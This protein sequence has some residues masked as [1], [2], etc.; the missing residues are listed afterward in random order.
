MTI[1][2]GLSAL[3]AASEAIDATSNNIANAQTI[4]YKAGQYV[5][6]DQFFRATDPQNPNRTGMG[7]V[8]T[9]IRRPQTNGSIVATSNPLDLAIGGLGMFTTAQT[10]V[11]GSV[12][13]NPSNF[14]Y[15]RNG[16]FGVDNQNRIV[17]ENG[18][19]LVGYPANPDGTINTSQ[20]S[21]LT[22]SQA[23]LPGSQTLKSQV[24][25]NLDNTTNP[26]SSTFDPT[27][28]GTYSQSTS[29]TIYDSTGLPHT[30][31]LYYVKQ[32]SV[33]LV[34]TP[35][36]AAGTFTYD[37]QQA[38]SATPVTSSN[39]E[40]DGVNNP[41]LTANG[42]FPVGDNV[43]AQILDGNGNP[44]GAPQTLAP[45]GG[46]ANITFP[47][48]GTAPTAGAFSIVLTDT[49]TNAPPVG[50]STTVPAVIPK[51]ATTSFPSTSTIETLS[52]ASVSQVSGTT[53]L[54][55]LQD[56]STLTVTANTAV[57]PTSFTIPTS[58]FAIYATID[59]NPVPGGVTGST[60]QYN[61]FL[62]ANNGYPSGS[63][64][65]FSINGIP[66]T[67]LGTMAF[68][69]GKNIDSLA[70]DAYGVPNFATKMNISTTV[71][72]TNKNNV[73]FSIDSTNMTAYSAVGQ[74]Y[75]NS[76]DGA[77]LSQ[78]SSY[79]FDNNGQ[80]VAVYS[81]GQSKVQG[82]VKLAVFN[83]D[84]GLI[85]I[86]GNS[87]EQSAL[88]GNPTF[89]TAGSGLFGGLKSQALEQSNVDLT[90]QLVTL[91]SL[92][93]QYSAASQVVKTSQSIEDDV[94]NKLS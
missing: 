33:P 76:Q 27:T 70:K 10:V 83:N 6:Q 34:L 9:Q 32:P 67:A 43:T 75:T 56:G 37:T 60:N 29:Q 85:P 42:T 14:Q 72:N 38:A 73:A 78:L 53:Y 50:V 31:S 91:M 39:F 81:N 18:N 84:E 68:V 19:Y 23:P 20:S 92:Q 55:T 16:Q 13:G 28:S 47:P 57:N 65:T 89:G 52:N 25:L 45:A 79:S 36:A 1:G 41:E 66:Q 12:T 94:L 7:T 82:Q 48:T 3:Q 22:L 15:T 58:R 5:F 93:R 51:V 64:N 24:S 86:G 44:L 49:T 17:N 21:V 4:G 80:L 88:S 59:G 46:S 26:V 90:S 77:P 61:Q 11:D 71:G 40:Y 87:F 35:G 63:S 30:L 2:I 54:L 62:N 69:G 8:V 74:T